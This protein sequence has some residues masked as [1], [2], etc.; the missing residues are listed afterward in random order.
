MA[1]FGARLAYPIPDRIV[2]R[3]SAEQALASREALDR[4]TPLQRAI[5]R[6]VLTLLG[7]RPT[8]STRDPHMQP[9]RMDLRDQRRRVA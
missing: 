8:P 1:N 9:T 2:A 6:V 3:S 7:M 4:S 5:A